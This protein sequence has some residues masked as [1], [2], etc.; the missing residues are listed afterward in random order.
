[1]AS[2]RMSA[3]PGIESVTRDDGQEEEG[4]GGSGTAR[5]GARQKSNVAL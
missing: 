2:F 3:P 1:M 4:A 5:V